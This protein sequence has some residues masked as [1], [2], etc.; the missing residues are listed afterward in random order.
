KLPG[1]D[2][3][4]GRRDVV[5]G[6]QRQRDVG[7]FHGCLGSSGRR[8]KLIQRREFGKATL[9]RRI[10]PA[11]L[12]Y[13]TAA[14]TGRNHC[15]PDSDPPPTSSNRPHPVLPAYYEGEAQRRGF[16]RKL[17]DQTAGDYDRIERTLSF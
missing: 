7:D 3:V 17:F 11:G 14:Q 5:P 13:T 12:P 2:A 15:M 4:R 16:V 6:K 10:P 1:M 9:A 8:G